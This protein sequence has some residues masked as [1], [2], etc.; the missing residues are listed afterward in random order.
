MH[1]EQNLSLMNLVQSKTISTVVMWN[2][3]WNFVFFFVGEFTLF[4]LLQ[5]H[6]F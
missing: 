2:F 5:L 6:I 1:R 4:N 3:Q